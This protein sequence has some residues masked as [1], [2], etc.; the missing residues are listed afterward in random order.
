VL[1][2][3]AGAIQEWRDRKPDN[4]LTLDFSKV[5]KAFADGMLGII[6]VTTDLRL[7]GQKIAVVP[8]ELPIP[9]KFFTA[10][11]WA[12]L[13]DPDN[14]PKRSQPHRR[15]FLQQFTTYKDLP[16]LVDGF[17]E[18]VM[19]HMEMPVDIL[20]A[21][22][23]SVNEVCDN[24]INHS[25]SAPGGF[26]Q[27]IAYPDSRIIA[28]TVAD[29]GRG[30]LTSLQEGFPCLETDVEAI[31]KAI[32]AGVTRNKAHGQG[33]GLAGTRRITTMTKGSLDIISGA[34][35]INIVGDAET[36]RVWKAERSFNGTCVS[37]QIRISHDFSVSKALTFGKTPYVPY[38]IVDAHY[39]LQEEDALLLKM[40]DQE[41]G[42]GSRAA[43]REMR[44]KA[45]NLIAAKPGFPLYL[46]WNNITIIASSF[47]DEF[48]GKIFVRLGKEKFEHTIKHLEIQPLVAQLIGKAIAERME[49][50]KE[51]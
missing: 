20:A 17:M 21:L 7:Q 46:N 41:T 50:P 5:Q 34:G 13:L 29:A 49:H 6:A 24:V 48:L 43:G 8:P 47:A 39:E 27:V 45:L 4:S 2:Q 1:P 23:W 19:R 14:V 18:I 16:G 44:M 36:P 25:N 37:G 40:E 42:T 28:F 33:N 51:D 31:T 26:L 32:E 11:N 22:E 30:I 35:R 3:F 10:T 9:Q 15:Q 38:T 12:H